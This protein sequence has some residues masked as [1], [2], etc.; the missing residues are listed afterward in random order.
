MRP[1]RRR[2]SFLAALGFAWFR[3]VACYVREGDGA[4][5]QFLYEQGGNEGDPMIG[6][7]ATNTGAWPPPAPP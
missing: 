4:K 5:R 6:S 7:P 2:A 1:E 3:R